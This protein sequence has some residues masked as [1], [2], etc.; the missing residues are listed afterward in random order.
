MAVVLTLAPPYR[1]VQPSQTR[2]SCETRCV[3]RCG[4]VALFSSFSQRSLLNPDSTVS[5]EPRPNPSTLVKTSPAP[6]PVRNSGTPG[7]NC[8]FKYTTARCRLLK[9]NDNGARGLAVGGFHRAE[10]RSS[11]PKRE[12]MVTHHRECDASF[13]GEGNSRC[14]AARV[15]ILLYTSPIVHAVV[16]PHC[17]IRVQ[18]DALGST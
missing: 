8:Q 11:G 7:K 18:V 1:D 2:T 13:N 12:T 9:I 15:P 10:P 14:F 3:P 17:F 16:Q 6:P 5:H 4:V